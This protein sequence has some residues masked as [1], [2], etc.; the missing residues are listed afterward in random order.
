VYAIAA[1]EAA[2]RLGVPAATAASSQLGA[3][4]FLR[5]AYA[6]A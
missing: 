3:A 5:L 1:T 4:D 6:A 2:R